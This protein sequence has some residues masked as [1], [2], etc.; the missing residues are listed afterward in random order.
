MPWLIL[1]NSKIN[2]R[3]AILRDDLRRLV[4]QGAAYSGAADEARISERIA[5]MEARLADLLNQRDVL[6]K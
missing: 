5:D 2:R 3:I 6:S 1:K 4:E